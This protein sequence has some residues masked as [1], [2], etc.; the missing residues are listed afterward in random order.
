MFQALLDNKS[1]EFPMF[2]YLTTLLLNECD[3]GYKYHV[4]RSILQNAP[5]L[6]Q[7][8]LHNCKVSFGEVKHMVHLALI[9]SWF[10]I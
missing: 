2:P 4:L 3:I 5:N 7:L 6:E 10:G 8:R 1:Q 9:P